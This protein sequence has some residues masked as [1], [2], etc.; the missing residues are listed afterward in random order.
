MIQLIKY[1]RI[2]L[3]KLKGMSL[4]IMLGYFYLLLWVLTQSLDFQ[5]IS[6]IFIKQSIMNMD[7]LTISVI[8]SLIPKISLRSKSCSTSCLSSGSLL[9]VINSNNVKK[10]NPRRDNLTSIPRLTQ[11][12]KT[13]QSNIER[14]LNPSSNQNS[15]IQS[16]FNSRL[17][18][19][20]GRRRR[21]SSWNLKN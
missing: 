15:L 11:F 19:P 10:R 18:M 3:E 12:P 20:S 2:Q 21:R 6:R 14:K 5:E 13:S 9:K 17:K 1:G 7:T 16:G 8:S 4:S